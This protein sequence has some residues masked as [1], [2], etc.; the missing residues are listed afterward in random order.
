[1][2]TKGRYEVITGYNYGDDDEDNNGGDDGDAC[3]DGGDDGVYQ[4]GLHPLAPWH[5]IGSAP[6]NC[7]QL[8]Q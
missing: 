4:A 6:A 2:P 8:L 3:D 1:M 7:L 5:N